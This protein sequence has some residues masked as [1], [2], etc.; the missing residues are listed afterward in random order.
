[1]LRSRI[2]LSQQ[3]PGQTGHRGEPLTSGRGDPDCAL[4]PG[5]D[6]LNGA[7][8]VPAVAAIM[9]NAFDHAQC[10]WLADVYN[11]RRIA[12]TPALRAYFSRNSRNF[13]RVLFDDK[14]DALYVRKG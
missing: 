7:G 4:S 6:G 1:M 3:G 13:V 9:R 14:G 12:W 2:L 5:R 10:V 8:R 11:R